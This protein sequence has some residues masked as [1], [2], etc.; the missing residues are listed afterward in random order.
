MV[1]GIDK[2]VGNMGNFL[3]AGNSNMRAGRLYNALQ[4]GEALKIST[5]VRNI[6]Q[7]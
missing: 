2:V 3:L 4:V 1:P 6:R 7:S 5:F